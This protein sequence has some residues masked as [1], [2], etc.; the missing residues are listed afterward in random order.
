MTEA[1]IQS[2]TRPGNLLDVPAVRQGLLLAG[3]A[4]S[5][6]IGIATA[7]WSRTPDYSLLYANLADRD[8]GAIVNA[9]MAAD[10]PHELEQ[11][12]GAVMVPAGRVH[13]ARLLL[14]SDGLPQ[15]SGLGFELIG[16]EKGLG[17]SQFMES[18]RYQHMLETELVRTIGNLRP[19]QGAR[20]HL[21]IPKQS[22]FVRDRRPASASVM[23]ELYPGRRLEE[24]QVA[25]IVHLVASSIPD[26][27][28]GEVTVVDQQGRLLTGSGKSSELALTAQQFEYRTR[29]E[30]A[31][32]QRIEDLLAPL[33]GAGKVRAQVNVDMDFTITEQTQET[34]D[35][36]TAALRSEQS[37][38]Q[39]QRENNATAGGIP[40]ALSNQP[41]AAETPP[42]AENPTRSSSN[43]ATRN[44]E[45]DRT[46]SHVR[47]PTGSIQKL[48]IAVIVDDR[49]GVGEDGTATT[50]PL[51]D[52]ELERMTTLVREA[53]GFNAERGD[54]V[55]V[56]NASFSRTEAA[57]PIEPAWWEM[58]LVGQV[59]RQIVG[60]VLV[61]GLIFGLLRP[62][63]RHLLTAPPATVLPTGGAEL[64]ALGH[65]A[66]PALTHEQS[67]ATARSLVGE[68]PKRAARVVKDWVS[69]D[70]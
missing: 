55:S 5:V 16:E 57:E 70:E 35:P 17:V 31:Y 40:G 51:T 43:T 13:E 45:L 41:P 67:M 9:L 22:V 60:V 54:T 6:A 62:T 50:T 56:F 11:T 39:T 66:A 69:E 64:G 21:A 15:G 25:A 63:V 26:L 14:A 18:A 2:G 61:L 65:A 47:Q 36:N 10:I 7:L 42:A 46:V 38:N 49:H 58:P 8:A 28:A 1:T 44:F 59:I 30:H 48:S 32:A 4:A 34:F 3:I 37:S 19:V 20:V 52:E 12:S 68:D 29:V 24:S 23:V 33:A 53:V 27:E